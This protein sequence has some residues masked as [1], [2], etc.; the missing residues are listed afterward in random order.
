[1]V[2]G[3]VAG[4]KAQHRQALLAARRAVPGATRTDEALALAGH[5]GEFVAPGDTV[6]AYLPVGTEPGSPHLVDRLR[7]LS[8]RVLLPVTRFGGDGEPLALMWGVYV[9]GALVAARFG[10]LEPAEPWLPSLVVAQADTVLVPALAVDRNGIR[11]GRGGGFYDRSLPLCRPGARLVA[12]VRDDEVVDEL[13][14]AAHDV[15][16]THALTPA[17]GLFALAHTL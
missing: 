9:P 5:L 16:M 1:M 15:R 14:S 10:L 6:C 11:L 7:E 13:P 12:V 8:A 2:D 3:V 17:Q 4:S